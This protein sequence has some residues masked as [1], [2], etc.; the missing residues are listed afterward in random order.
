MRGISVI[1]PT[2]N[3]GAYLREAVSSA[4]AQQYAPVEVIVV[5]DGSTDGS[6][7]ALP[8]TSGLRLIR[9]EHAG[10]SAARNTGIAAA[11]HE[12]VAFLDADDLWMPHRLVQMMEIWQEGLFVTTDFYLLEEGVSLQQAERVGKTLYKA[13]GVQQGTDAEAWFVR[14]GFRVYPLVAKQ[15]IEAAGGF[16]ETRQ[17]AE[18]RD[19]WLRLIAHGLHLRAVNA[20]PAGFHRV[21][22]RSASHGLST[23]A[24]LKWHREIVATYEKVLQPGTALSPQ[25]RRLAKEA[26]DELKAQW[27]WVAGL[28]ALR[29]GALREGTGYLREGVQAVGPALFFRYLPLLLKSHVLSK[30]P[31]RSTR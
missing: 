6:L 22:Q 7:A 31:M 3:S 28:D 21:R 27:S 20:P 16:D 2:Y 12:L 11:S 15:A 17:M 24:W 9:R 10:V 29:H 1:I 18:D 30:I 19:L 25:L 4:L 8:S 26:H 14:Y 13:Y 5:D 23:A